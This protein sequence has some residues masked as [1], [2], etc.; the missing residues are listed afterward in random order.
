MLS[1]LYRGEAGSGFAGGVDGAGAEGEGEE[2]GGGEA[3][4]AHHVE[5]AFALG[6][7]GY[8]FGEVGVGKKLL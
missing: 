7:G 5:H 2:A 3:G 1:R 4:V 8:G 6:H